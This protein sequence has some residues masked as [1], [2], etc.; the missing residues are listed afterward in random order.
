MTSKSKIILPEDTIDVR[1]FDL[2]SP[3]HRIGALQAILDN[4]CK[5]FERTLKHAFYQ[6]LRQPIDIHVEQQD[7]KKLQEYLKTLNQPSV[8]R[9]FTVSPH[10]MHGTLAMESQVLYTMVDLFFGGKG[11]KPRESAEMSDTE[12]RLVERFF[13]VALEHFSSAWHSVTDWQSALTSK[14]TLRLGGHWQSNP[15]YQICRFKLS[16]SGQEG[17]FDI[18]LPF[19]GLD[20]LRDLQFQQD[21]LETDPEIRARVEQKICQAP[22]RLN[23]TLAE[24]RL[25][26]G[27]VMDLRPGDVIPIELPGEVTV[28]AGSTS[29]YSARVAQNNSSLVLQIQRVLSK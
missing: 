23:A 11:T 18:A 10:D 14:N 28:R 13:H 29:L 4:V 25:P 2:A 7:T 22:L 21:E 19:N 26:L 1:D 9:E 20:F 6:L 3:E 8:Y 5:Q 17:W 27:D 15:L 12:V 16:I 24:R